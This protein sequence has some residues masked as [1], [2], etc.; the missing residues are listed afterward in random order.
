MSLEKGWLKR[1]IEEV[2]KEMEELPAWLKKV[3]EIKKE[4]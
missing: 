3:I 4:K 1:T 2:R